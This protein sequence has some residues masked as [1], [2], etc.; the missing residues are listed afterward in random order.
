MLEPELAASVVGHVTEEQFRRLEEN[1]RFCAQPVTNEEEMRA[2]REAELVFH[3]ILAEVCPN[4]VLASC[5]GS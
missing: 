3:T 4:P 1:V 2:H 5:V